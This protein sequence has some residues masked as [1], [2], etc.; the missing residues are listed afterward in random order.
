[1]RN[2]I[3]EEMD[4]LASHDDPRVLAVIEEMLERIRTILDLF[5]GIIHE[6]WHV[7]QIVM[8]M[9]D[10][11]RQLFRTGKSARNKDFQEYEEDGNIPAGV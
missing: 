4:E 5:E 11:I 9:F 6:V 2:D 3:Q 7:A 10:E 1:M 8:D